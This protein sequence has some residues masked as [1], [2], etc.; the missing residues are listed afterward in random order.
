MAKIKNTKAVS[1]SV[2]ALETVEVVETESVVEEAPA[3][4]ETTKEPQLDINAIYEMM[5]GFQRTINELQAQLEVEKQKNAAAPVVQTVSDGGTEKLIELLGNKKSDREVTIIHNRELLGGLS[6]SIRLTGISIDFHTLGEERVL[7][8]QQFEECVSKYRRWFDKEIILLSSEH[9]EL[10]ERY[11]VP[12]L[13]RAGK[14][15]ITK[16]DLLNLY[17]MDERKL[18][19]YVTSLTTEDQNFVCSY[20]LGKCYQGDDKY[21]NRSKIELLNRISHKGVFDTLL[22]AMNFDS[23]KN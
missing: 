23:V 1:E 20:W 10:S 8:W 7:S 13:K 9:A 19:D 6:T 14:N 3:V 16:G 11:N 12:C 17:R 22:T 18:E 21:L 4:E 5:A 2:D 15:S